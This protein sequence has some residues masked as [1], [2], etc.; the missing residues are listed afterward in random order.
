MTYEK[1]TEPVLDFY[2]KM[3]L[4]RVVNGENSINQIYKEISDIIDT[5][6]A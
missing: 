1:S 6:E 2:E 5:L 4:L 3:N